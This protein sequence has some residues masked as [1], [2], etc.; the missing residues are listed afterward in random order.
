IDNVKNILDANGYA[1]Q[2]TPIFA[3]FDLLR[4]ARRL[5]ARSFAIDEHPGRNLTFPALDLGQALLE[6]IKRS[7]TAFA[8][9]VG[10][11]MESCE[12]GDTKE[13]EICGSLYGM[14]VTPPW[15]PPLPRSSSRVLGA[16][17]LATAPPHGKGRLLRCIPGETISRTP[18]PPAIPEAVRGPGATAWAQ[19]PAGTGP[20][21]QT[22]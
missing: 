12:H 13:G 7:R 2:G 17:R 21:K 8:D 22:A 9:G 20:R 5:G 14:D 19:G 16:N 18:V 6:D 10:S 4:Q 11:G 1:M 15:P 3:L